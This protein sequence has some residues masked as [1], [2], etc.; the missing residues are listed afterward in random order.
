M[1]IIFANSSVYFIFYF[2]HA[3]ICSPFDK[4]ML[5]RCITKFEWNNSFSLLKWLKLDDARAVMYINELIL[6]NKQTT[7]NVCGVFVTTTKKGFIILKRISEAPGRSY[8]YIEDGFWR[9]TSALIHG[10]IRNSAYGTVMPSYTKLMLYRIY[11]FFFSCCLPCKRK[12]VLKTRAHSNC[13]KT[14]LS[15]S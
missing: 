2:S 1:Q 15:R 7:R 13:V 6:N 5:F 9:S 4:L 14:L 10:K 3:E 11:A 12:Y 8:I